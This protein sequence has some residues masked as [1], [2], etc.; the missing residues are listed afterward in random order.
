MDEKRLFRR[1][2]Y[3][4]PVEYR[5]NE[6]FKAEKNLGGSI[7]YDLSEAGVR[8]QVDDFI[9]PQTT[10]NV[11]L[12]LKPERTFGLEARVI[13]AQR[14]PHSENYQLGLQFTDISA[15]IQPQKE[16][17]RYLETRRS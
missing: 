13:W 14:V 15:N 11:N 2:A 17:H 16:L 6:I 3:R 5:I 7:A 8:L 9:A 4:E 12:R 1:V 10:M